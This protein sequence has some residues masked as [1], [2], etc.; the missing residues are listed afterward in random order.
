MRAALSLFIASVLVA[1]CG[2]SA[3][4]GHP[5]PSPS[6]AAASATPAATSIDQLNCRLPVAGYPPSLSKSAAIATGPD[7]QPGQAGR[8]RRPSERQIHSRG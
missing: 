5:S 8:V 4:G 6:K 1:A 7:G 2:T 3:T